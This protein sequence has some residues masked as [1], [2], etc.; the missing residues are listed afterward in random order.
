M[1]AEMNGLTGELD[2]QGQGSAEHSGPRGPRGTP[3]TDG[4][5]GLKGGVGERG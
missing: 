5:P 4:N 3:G 1:P 2:H